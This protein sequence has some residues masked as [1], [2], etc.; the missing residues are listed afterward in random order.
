MRSVKA[1][2]AV[3][4]Y[5]VL[6]ISFIQLAL[7]IQFYPIRL[8]SPNSLSALLVCFQSQSSVAESFRGCRK[9]CVLWLVGLAF[10]VAHCFDL[11]LFVG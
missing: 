3:F 7:G 5:M 1:I 9:L 4:Y 10:L 11:V 6:R 8:F 2:L